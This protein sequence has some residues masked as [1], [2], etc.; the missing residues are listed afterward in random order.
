MSERLSRSSAGGLLFLIFLLSLGGCHRGSEL[1]ATEVLNNT[2]CKG[3]TTGLRKVEFADV[4]AMRGSTLISLSAP[5]AD[6][7]A[8]Q[9]AVPDLL[10]FSLSKGRQPTP[11]YAFRLT[12]ARLVDGVAELTL[13]WVTPEPDSVQPQVITYPCIVVGV[14]AGD[15]SQVRAVDEDGELLGELRI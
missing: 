9:S 11:G 7:V 3:A 2:N 12:D 14:E 13:R 4:A 15:F 6:A 1:A 5:V 8:G 10:L